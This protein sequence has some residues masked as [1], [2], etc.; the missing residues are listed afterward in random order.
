[1]VRV[2]EERVLVG[3]MSGAPVLDD[4]QPAGREPVLDAM[5]E[6]D[7][8]VAHVLLEPMTRE[9]TLAALARHDRGDPSLLQP[10][11]QPT[12]L[13]AQDGF[14]REAGEERLDRVEN[15]PSSADGVD[16][17]P[18]ADKEPLEVVLSGLLDLVPLDPNVIERE[19]PGRLEPPEIE[20]ERA[21]V[22]DQLLDP[23]LEAHEHAG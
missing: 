2:D 10:G 22:R 5:I 12:E 4:P 6:Q 15:H 20:A 8:A 14:V 17:V 1:P 16:R 23:L 18:E 21:D 11:E 3:A 9:L 13:R 19:L 7:H